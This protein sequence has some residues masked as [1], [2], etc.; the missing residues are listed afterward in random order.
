MTGLPLGSPSGVHVLSSFLTLL[1]LLQV[2][3]RCVTLVA[4][5]H[6]AP[7]RKDEDVVA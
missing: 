3:A 6:T 5:E 4:F 1:Q 2:L 7:D